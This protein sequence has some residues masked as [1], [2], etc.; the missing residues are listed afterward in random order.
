[1]FAQSQS[2]STLEL[3][4]SDKCMCKNTR[5]YRT[6]MQLLYRSPRSK[7]VHIL[8]YVFSVDMPAST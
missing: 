3:H 8:E 4:T 5:V 1:M 2:S 6:T 7:L